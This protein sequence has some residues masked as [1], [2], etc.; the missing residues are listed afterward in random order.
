MATL[1]ELLQ[2]GTRIKFEGG[3]PPKIGEVPHAAYAMLDATRNLEL[4]DGPQ[5][6]THEQA[7]EPAKPQLPPEVQRVGSLGSELAQIARM[8][9]GI[10]ATGEV[11]R[12]DKKMHVCFTSPEIPNFSQTPKT[13]AE[14][15]AHQRAR[16]H[17]QLQAQTKRPVFSHK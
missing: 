12:G 8:F 2:D 9:P 3:K 7:P 17:A 4:L 10:K 16:R 1:G 6:T 13:D 14:I 15:K 5:Q 11:E